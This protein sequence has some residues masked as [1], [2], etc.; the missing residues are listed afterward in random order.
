M[1]YHGN[2]VWQILEGT[3]LGLEF[4][5]RE[6][7]GLFWRLVLSF[8]VLCDYYSC[9]WVVADLVVELLGRIVPCLDLVL[10]ATES[11]LLAAHLSLLLH[12]Y[13]SCF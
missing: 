11:G 13:Y 10:M 6:S 4:G 12:A 3:F 9:F 8:L 5:Q 1:S 2:P 7:A